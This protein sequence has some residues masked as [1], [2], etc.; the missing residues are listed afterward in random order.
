[1]KKRL[2]ALLC[3]ITCVLSLC[4]CGEVVYTDK[5]KTTMSYCEQ[6]AN[7]NLEL[8]TTLCANEA[9]VSEL[10][11]YNKEEL[12]YIYTYYMSDLYGVNVDGKL[13]AFNGMLT[14]Y[15]Q[16]RKEMGTITGTGTATSVISGD[17]VIVTI[18]L[19]GTEC[20]GQ[21]V[22]TFSNDLFT[23]F[24]EAE[25]T[26]NT[27]FAQKMKQA[28]SNM[29]TAGLNTLLGMG[30][31]FIM[32][33]LIC[34]IISSF[35]FIGT[36][37]KKETKKV[38]APVVAVSQSEPEELSDDTELVAVIMAA[39]SA[40]EGNASTDGFVVRSIRRANRRN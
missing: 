14:T 38:E 30:T 37:G 9:T 39:I 7:A 10:L 28:G 36:A 40:Y 23:K 32:L 16:T 29:G 18:P 25:A 34:F 35:K 21:F 15:L 11:T 13:G 20:N 27:S 33:I 12:S 17:K 1:M 19:T 3:A 24:I 31:V 22:C 26:A 4:A 2:L 5:Q 8:A 6:L